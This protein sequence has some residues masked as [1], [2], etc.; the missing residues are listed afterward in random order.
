MSIWQC[1]T[2]GVE[3]AAEPVAADVCPICADERQYV[4]LDGQVWTTVQ[5]Q[6]DQGMTL[7]VFDVEPGL[8]GITST[9]IGIGQQSMLVV[10]PAGNLLWDPVG[11]ISADAVAAVAAY[12]PV[13]AVAASHPHMFGVQVE[14][15]KALEA[16]V[17]VN[18]AD[19][20]FL[21]RSDDRVEYWF[22]QYDVVPGVTL[23]QLG[24]H[25][26]GSAV[27]HWPAGNEG[28]GVILAGDTIFVNQDR[29]AAFMRSYPNKIPLSAAV[30]DRI[31]KAV[32]AFE[33]DRLY[34]NFGSVIPA[35]ASAVV[36]RSADRHM[37]WVRGDFDD[38]T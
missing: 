23:H 21:Q 4:P 27:V 22:G 1:A 3:R 8:V 15:A 7:D 19:A 11:L 34:N 6:I 5:A 36:R 29:T 28:K 32:L 30:V 31:A 9:G 37:A 35:G 24:G 18:Q 25:F 13:V 2:C 26:K 10:T 14:W 20:E 38:L 12:G 16:K 33:F 17:L